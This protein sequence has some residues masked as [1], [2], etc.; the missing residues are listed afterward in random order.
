MQN[1]LMKKIFTAAVLISL[2]I[3]FLFFGC[4]KS[5]SGSGDNCAIIQQ[6]KIT[7]AKTTYYVGD[8]IF[9]QTNKLAPIAL[10]EWTHGD[11]SNDVSTTQGLFIY[12][13]SKNDE[14]WYYLAVSYPDCAPHF[15]SVYINVINAPATAP[16]SPA[17]N[18]V[19]FS[20][21]PNIS[22]PSTTF[23]YD[24][25]YNC[26]KLYGYYGNGYPD[27]NMYFEFYWNDK[28]PE[29]GA[30]SIS[31]TITFMDD[32]P[33]TVF[34]ASTYSSIY[35][36]ADPGTVYISHVNGKLH[37]TFCNLTLEG[38]LGGPAYTTTASGEISA[39]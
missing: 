33:Y 2:I 14:G 38:D 24:P 28:E 19:S 1:N 13:C 12:P 10:Y 34:I 3:S 8:T 22:F 23:A 37:A 17:N 31:S 39:P 29:D 36:Q 27:F 35:F 15:D 9:L 25:D 5:G 7:G 11:N 20:A 18:S 6:I 30:Y 26:K 16:C 21:I 32:N 4:K